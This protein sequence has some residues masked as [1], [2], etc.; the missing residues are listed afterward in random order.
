MAKIFCKI[1]QFLIIF[2]FQPILAKISKI[3]RGRLEGQSP[4]IL[5]RGTPRKIPV[6]EIPRS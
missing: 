3:I 6:K 5:E 1:S 4:T 2:H